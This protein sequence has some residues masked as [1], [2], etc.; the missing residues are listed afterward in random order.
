MTQPVC[1]C[2]ELNQHMLL[3]LKAKLEAIV[4]SFCK[5]TRFVFV[6][7][8][9]AVPQLEPQ[10]PPP[11]LPQPL[12]PAVHP[13]ADTPLALTQSPSLHPPSSTSAAPLVDHA[14]LSQ[15]PPLRQRLGDD[16][17]RLVQ[18]KKCPTR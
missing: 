7:R 3:H 16:L 2:C 14:A 18:V 4:H 8:T 9:Q 10:A 17:I 6:D 15:P 1:L 11:S 12:P 5:L 13:A